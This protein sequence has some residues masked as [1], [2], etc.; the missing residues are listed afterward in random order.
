MSVTTG[1]ATP[2]VFGRIFEAGVTQGA[3][4]VPGIVAE[5]GHGP[6]ASNPTTASTWT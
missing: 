3:G 6:N 4:N 5:L 1:L 2:S